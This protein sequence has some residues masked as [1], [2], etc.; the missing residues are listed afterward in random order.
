MGYGTL[1]LEGRVGKWEGKGRERGGEEKG[2]KGEGE[3]RGR[4]ERGGG[5][6]GGGG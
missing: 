1:Y 2:G 6:E 5:G 4:V 3:G